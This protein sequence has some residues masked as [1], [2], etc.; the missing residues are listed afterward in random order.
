VVATSP[1]LIFGFAVLHGAAWGIRGPLMM[2]IRADYFGRR[3][4][5]TIEG[6]AGVITTSGI[7]V[8]PLLVA[9]MADQLGNYRLA[10]VVVACVTAVGSLFFALARRPEMSLMRGSA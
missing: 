7:V 6:F 3:S 9:A 2:A 4:F 5:A 10:F 8:G 1:L